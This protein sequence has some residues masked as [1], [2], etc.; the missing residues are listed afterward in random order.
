MI[1]KKTI[2]GANFKYY[3]GKSGDIASRL[4]THRSK[5]ANGRREV[6]CLKASTS[7]ERVGLMFPDGYAELDDWERRETLL[8]MYEHGIDNVRGWRFCYRKHS[9][10][11]RKEILGNLCSMKNS[12]YRCGRVGHFGHACNETHYAPWAGGRV[13]EIKK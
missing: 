11:H 6:L 1:G 2:K 7:F 5:G 3:I 8:N 13:I 10:A 12:C 9:D 4:E